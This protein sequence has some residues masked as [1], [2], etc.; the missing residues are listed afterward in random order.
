[1]QKALSKNIIKVGPFFSELSGLVRVTPDRILAYVVAI[2]AVELQTVWLEPKTGTFYHGLLVL[3]MLH[4]Y[5]L[6]RDDPDRKKLLLL[7]VIPLLRVISMAMPV[8]LIPPLYRY[9]MVGIPVIISIGIVLR[10]TA[11]PWSKIGLQW[12]SFR[13]SDQIWEN[14]LIAMSGIP[15]GLMGYYFADPIPLV[16]EFHW[17]EVIAS[18]L[19]VILYIAILEEVVF[20]GMLLNTL[21][22]TFGQFGILMA[23]ILYTLLFASYPSIEGIILMGFSSL[24]YSWHVLESRS[25]LAATISHTFMIVG[26]LIIWPIVF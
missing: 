17:G 3:I 8:G 15:L 24:L 26:M 19:V 23:S 1:M 9:P 6:A 25:I 4:H 2:A 13:T 20:R 22:N 14:I 12:P 11:I 21:K 16:T 18:I 10:E 7:A 5:L